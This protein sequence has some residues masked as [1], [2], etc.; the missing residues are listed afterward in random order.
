MAAIN[1]M[2]RND[3]IFVGSNRVGN[4][5]FFV[6]EKI[7]KN[8]NF[9]IPNKNTLEHFVDWRIRESRDN[10]GNLSYLSGHSRHEE[11]SNCE[12]FNLGNSKIIK[13]REIL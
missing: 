11:I 3:L 4:N 12:I 13:V 9:E 2:E 1:V 7:A 6:N 10:L 8:I 5:A